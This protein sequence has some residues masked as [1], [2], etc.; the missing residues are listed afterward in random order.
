MLLSICP[1]FAENLHLTIRNPDILPVAPRARGGGY[2]NL[3]GTFLSDRWSSSTRKK[4]ELN[5]K[6]HFAMIGRKDSHSDQIGVDHVTVRILPP[7]PAS[8]AP[9]DSTLQ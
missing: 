4:V 7:Q 5:T 9:G 6:S 2:S 8:P 3:W 1:G